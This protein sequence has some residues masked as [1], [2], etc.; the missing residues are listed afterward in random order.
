[1]NFTGY[2]SWQQRRS[3]FRPFQRPEGG[4]NR[5]PQNWQILFCEYGY[6]GSSILKS[7]SFYDHDYDDQKE[8]RW[9]GDRLQEL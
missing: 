5:N 4:G 2:M 3:N 7:Q 9:I 1:M 8:Y 6:G